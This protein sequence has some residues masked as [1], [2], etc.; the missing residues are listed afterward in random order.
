MLSIFLRIASTN[1]KK[2]ISKVRKNHLLL[3]LLIPTTI[4]PKKQ[5]NFPRGDNEINGVQNGASIIKLTKPAK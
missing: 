5:T 1:E 3:V 4:C 2:Q